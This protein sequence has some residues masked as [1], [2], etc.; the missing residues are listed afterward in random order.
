MV[1]TYHKPPSNKG[2]I[3]AISILAILL[4]ASVLVTCYLLYLKKL[5]SQGKGPYDISPIMQ[6]S[7]SIGSHGSIP[8]VMSSPGNLMTTE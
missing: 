6:S 8:V 1:T 4:V 7:T 2:Y 5:E 3:A